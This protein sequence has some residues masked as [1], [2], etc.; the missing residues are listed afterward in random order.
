MLA[1]LGAGLLARPG[2]AQGPGGGRTVV[3]SAKRKVVLPDKVGRVFVAG[4][5]ASVMVIIYS[6]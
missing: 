2:W 4:P 1:L 6:R 5:P 3:D